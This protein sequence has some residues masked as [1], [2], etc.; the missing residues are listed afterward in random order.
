MA[1]GEHAAAPPVAPLSMS[2]DPAKDSVFL[3][4]IAGQIESAEVRSVGIIPLRVLLV[5]V[6]VC[7]CLH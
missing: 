3:V 4:M 2:R 6:C 5:N 1:E 7:V